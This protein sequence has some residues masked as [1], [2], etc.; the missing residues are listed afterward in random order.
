M[1]AAHVLLE[2]KQFLPAITLY[3]SILKKNGFKN[4]DQVLKALAR[5]HY[6]VAKTNKD[7]DA[8]RTARR[9]IQRAVH[10]NPCDKTNFFN[11]AL[12]EQQ[13]ATVLND[14]SLE[15]RCLSSLK[16]AAQNLLVA[17]SYL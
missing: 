10:V 14:Q 15:N 8:M 1:L 6:I 7:V 3:E 9:Y 11:L 13:M 2:N 4:D 5:A 12:L 16:A 17:E